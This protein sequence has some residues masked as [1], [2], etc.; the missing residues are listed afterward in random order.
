M[1]KFNILFN[2]ICIRVKEQHPSFCVYFIV[3]L[4]LFELSVYL[5]NRGCNPLKRITT[6]LLYTLF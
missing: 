3:K 1:Q 5:S 2:D 6:T 4:Y